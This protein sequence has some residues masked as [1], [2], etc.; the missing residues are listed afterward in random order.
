VFHWRSAVID[1]MSR[2]QSPALRASDREAF[3]LSCCEISLIEVRAIADLS[4]PWR[5][6]D[7]V[8]ES[9]L[10]RILAVRGIGE[11][12][13]CNTETLLGAWEHMPVWPEV[14]EALA[15]L[16]ARYLVAPHLIVSLRVAA[17]S[18]RT[19][20]LNWDAVLSCD[21]LGTMKPSPQSYARASRERPAG[22]ADLL[23]RCAPG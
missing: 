14:P 21:A 6:F 5:L 16:R 4:V 10:D 15:R 1:A 7:A 2:R 8:P 23:R 9:S 17:F 18:S 3:G 12:P 11:I 19:A 13:V 20:G 22:G